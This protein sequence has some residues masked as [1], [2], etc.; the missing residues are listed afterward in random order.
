M[1]RQVGWASELGR[2]QVDGQV[3]LSLFYF[4]FLFSFSFICFDLVLSTKPF[5]FRLIILQG[6]KGLSQSP[7]QFL[8]IIGHI[9]D[10]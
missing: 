9:F 3:V 7:S 5:C 6:L 8:R 4:C 2:L 1:R 10:I